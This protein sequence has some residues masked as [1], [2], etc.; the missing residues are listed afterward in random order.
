MRSASALFWGAVRA[1]FSVRGRLFLARVHSRAV[2][3]PR[4]L[5][6]PAPPRV[7]TCG[8][9][10][11]ARCSSLPAGVARRPRSASSCRRPG[12]PVSLLPGRA[13]LGDALRRFSPPGRPFPSLS[14]HLPRTL[15]AGLSLSLRSP[16]RAPGPGPARRPRTR[17]PGPHAQ[18]RLSHAP[19]PAVWRLSQR[20]NVALLHLTPGVAS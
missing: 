14:G 1:E 7:H 13:C 2:V 16:S 6:C 3:V 20:T 11:H 15:S 9:R 8:P 17:V 10:T 18:P 19:P 5:P 4:A 12:R